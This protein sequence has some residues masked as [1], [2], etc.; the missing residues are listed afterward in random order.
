MNIKKNELTLLFE[1]KNE[2]KISFDD[3]YET[4]IKKDY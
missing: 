2:S 1:K 3:I 4:L